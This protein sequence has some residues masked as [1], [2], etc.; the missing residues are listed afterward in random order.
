MGNLTHDGGQ[1][2]GPNG[3]DRR[4]YERR[5]VRPRLYVLLGGSGNDGILNDVSEGGVALDLVG[6][7]PPGEYVDVDFE[8]PELGCHLE[9]KGRVTWR[10]ESAK[11]VGVT[12]VDL[13]EAARGQIRQWI[14][15]KSASAEAAR[16]AVVL[17]AD[18]QAA[19]NA[20]APGKRELAVAQP[21]ETAT[22]PTS[23]EARSETKSEATSQTKLE[24]PGKARIEPSSPSEKK[25]AAAA[26]TDVGTAGKP[27]GDLVQDLVDSFKTP[28]KTPDKKYADVV[29]TWNEHS[30]GWNL[31]TDFFST[32]G[33]W[34][35]VV[36]GAVA[37]VL[38]L[39][40]IGVAAHRLPWRKA[41]SISVSKAGQSPSATAQDSQN[42]AAAN[43]GSV[44][45]AGNTAGNEIRS[46]Q[47]ASV[48]DQGGGNANNASNS[49]GSNGS[50]GGANSVTSA[51]SL[52][53]GLASAL[54]N[55]G[56][57]PCVNLGPRSGKIRIYFWTEK[58]TPEAIVAIYAKN[59][60]AVQDV[61][62]VDKVPYDLVLY[63]NGARVNGSGS[64]AGFMWSSRVFR[65]WYC[66][67][68]A[69][70]LEQP[71]VNE[72]LHYVAGANLDQRIQAEVA[73]LILH[74]FESIRN[75]HQKQP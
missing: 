32:G 18:R 27:K 69:G 11:K 31:N 4:V 10:D 20:P 19:F 74:T 58:A 47:G 16:P 64:E 9:A 68:A 39:L 13:P 53:P 21:V 26:Q 62:L 57:S 66:G 22:A 29:A 3:A 60:K 61:Q 72:S 59:L 49:N 6:S 73:Y 17:D 46:D 38:V 8:M 2:P 24:A 28:P 41:T 36:V 52:P 23:V 33:Y 54:S 35:W 51:P 44:G 12:F 50:N 14:A 40:A 1:V 70:L 15:M 67:Q 7:E 30:T 43:T 48:Q 25:T 55:G 75:E 5:A 65:P 45:D 37:G 63:V 42:Q 56:Q 71:E 34:R